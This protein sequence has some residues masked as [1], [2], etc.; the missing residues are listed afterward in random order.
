MTFLIKYLLS[1]LI[2]A[3]ILNAQEYNNIIKGI[4]ISSLQQIEDNNGK[5]YQNGI[6]K[7][8]LKI[9]KE[10][11]INT[12]RLRL[13]HNPQS[14]YNNFSKTLIFAQRIKNMGLNFILDFHYSDSWADPS[15][16][17]KP[18]KWK[19]LTF[20]ELKDSVYLYTKFVVGSLKQQNTIP[21][22]IQIGN[23]ITCGFLWDDGKICD[24]FN[25]EEQWNKFSDLIKEGIRGVNESLTNEDSVKIMLHIDNGGNNEICRWFLD[26][27][28][29]TEI[30]YDIIGLSFYPWWHGSLDDLKYNIND[31]SL[32]YDKE[33]II[34]ETAYPWTLNWN[35]NTHNI[36][37]N[38]DQLLVDYPASV[39]GQKRYIE[40]L[41][42]ITTS[43]NNNLLGLVYWE[44][45]WISTQSFGSSWENLALF[46]FKGEVLNSIKVFNNNTV[47][48]NKENRF[49]FELNQNYP[50]PF[51][52][53]TSIEYS[54]VS[55]EYVSLK[56]YD[57]LGKEIA[58]LV[59]EQQRAGRYRV[60][61]DASS[62][63]S[64]VYIYRLSAGKFSDSKKM[65]LTK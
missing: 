2:L 4:D 14:S 24:S 32:R 54:V 47:K 17:V 50:N 31:L 56:V 46:D 19:E 63:A 34:A 38:S 35:D 49:V 62:L 60:N 41:L 22:I 8:P 61:F 1:L 53:T 52:P 20:D 7:D 11:G 26:N 29:Q 18:N 30:S 25:N 64:G 36:I 40:E 44:P 59:N 15:Q 39:E 55:S 48:V 21:E 6:E 58:T 27:L 65:V 10:N 51:N 13:W 42:K 5:F 57:M 33:I 43:Q 9:F 37:G 12:V 45:A 16:Q 28:N 23:E 3:S